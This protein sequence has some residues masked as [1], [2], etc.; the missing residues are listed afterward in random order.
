MAF[1]LSLVIL[2]PL[3]A[4]NLN[5]KMLLAVKEKRKNRKYELQQFYNKSPRG[6]TKSL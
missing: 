3:V 4:S 5:I 1:V 2:L 6:C